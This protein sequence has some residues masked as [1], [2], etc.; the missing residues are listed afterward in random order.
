MKFYVGLNSDDL[1]SQQKL[2]GRNEELYGDQWTEHDDY[3]GYYR[4]RWKMAMQT[5]EYQMSI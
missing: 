3:A 1:F 4:V 5:L 2:N